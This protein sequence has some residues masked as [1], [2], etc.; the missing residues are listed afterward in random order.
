MMLLR[1]SRPSLEVF[2]TCPDI[3]H[4]ILNFIL[5]TRITPVTGNLRLY[6]LLVCGIQGWNVAYSISNPQSFMSPSEW[7]L[8]NVDCLL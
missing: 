5:A 8:K 6:V 3:Y 4:L 2:G 7:N 1:T